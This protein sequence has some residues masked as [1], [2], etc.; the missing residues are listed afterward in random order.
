MLRLGQR[1]LAGQRRVASPT[2]CSASVIGGVASCGV[3]GRSPPLAGR[4]N[5]GFQRTLRR[6]RLIQSTGSTRLAPLK[7]TVG[8]LVMGKQKHDKKVD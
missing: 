7:P 3:V 8:W 2:P 5:T 4:P 6:A 1:T